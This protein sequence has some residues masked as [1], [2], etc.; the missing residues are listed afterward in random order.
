MALSCA[1]TCST[2]D[3]GA[4][5]FNSA[6]HTSESRTGGGVLSCGSTFE[7]VDADDDDDDDDDAVRHQPTDSTSTRDTLSVESQSTDKRRAFASQL[8]QTLNC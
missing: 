6:W 8:N 5:R 1:V 7:R 2:R 3:T 4:A